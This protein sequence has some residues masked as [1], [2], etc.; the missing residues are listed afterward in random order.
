MTLELFLD[1][2]KIPNTP[3]SRMCFEAVD[4]DGTGSIEVKYLLLFMMNNTSA[5]RDEVLKFAFNLF[6]E[7]QQQIVSYQDLL[8]ILQAMRYA[9]CIEDVEQKGKILG[10]QLKEPDHIGYE[11]FMSIAQENPQIF[12]PVNIN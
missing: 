7:E 2:L 11:E 6:D 12:F 9:S 1:F 8:Q 5:P 10:H 3:L 4:F